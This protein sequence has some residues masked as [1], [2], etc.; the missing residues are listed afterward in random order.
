MNQLKIVGEEISG[1]KVVFSITM[2]LEHGEVFGVLAKWSAATKEHTAQS[3]VDF[4]NAKNE[5]GIRAKLKK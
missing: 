2:N 3:L 4:I 5:L 1:K